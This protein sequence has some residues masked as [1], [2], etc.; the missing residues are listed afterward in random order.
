V[1]VAIREGAAGIWRMI[2]ERLRNLGT[3]VLETAVNW[4]MTRI[5]TIVGARLTALA[6][7]AGFSAI[8]EAVVAVYQ[9]I[10]TAIEY[11]RRIIQVLITV[12]DTVIQIAQ[13]VIDPAARGVETGLR[14][15][16]PIVI[17]FL[18]NYAG[19]GGIGQRIRE[20]ID[21]VRAR[22]DAAILWLIDRALAAGRWILDRLRAGVA[23]VVN[24]WRIRKRFR[25]A[26]GETHTLFFRGEGR[27]AA[28]MLATTETTYADFLNQ[29]TPTTPAETQ[30]LALARPI[31]T[32]I[33]NLKTRVAA[34]A[35]GTTDQ[36]PEFT[37][38]LNNLA[39]QTAVFTM[40]QPG[41][42]PASTPPEY[43]PLNAAGFA[44]GMRI[45][46]L[47]RIGPPGSEPAVT[48]PVWSKLDRRSRP[49][50]DEYYYVLG[51]LLSERLHGPGTLWQNLT[52]LSRSGNGRHHE[53][54]END[55][56][57]HTA[58]P[59][60]KV[61]RYQVKV[62]YNRPKNQTLIDRF[63]NSADP[64][65]NA[66][67]KAAKL[68]I[69]ESEQYVPLGLKVTA[70]EVDPVSG[71]DVPHPVVNIGPDRWV[72]NR[73]DPLQYRVKGEAQPEQLRLPF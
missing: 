42:V 67:H 28:L 27:N 63:N 23:A 17:G 1:S 22:V 13:G 65:F 34:T 60:N 10:Q 3:M 48:N 4:V 55:L 18:A 47:S 44:K 39:I 36:T 41:Q 26:A 2:V 73:I 57:T 64:L 70:H 68:D 25:N 69:L 72:P 12:F 38:L 37:Q 61:F 6:A 52:P 40:R 56:K 11:A 30:A 50:N 9:A 24:W 19:L 62:E 51:H 54:V 66:P 58:S 49:N 43:D 7:S 32:Q 33:D 8:I 20:I 14:M 31:A 46:K 21:G 35:P 59:N 71:Q 15:I 29:L 53:T 16:M 45:R 5:I